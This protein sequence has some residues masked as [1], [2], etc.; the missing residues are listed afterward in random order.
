MLDM[1]NTICRNCIVLQYKTQNVDLITYLTIIFQ[2]YFIIYIL[3]SENG[4]WSKWNK[5]T[6]TFFQLDFSCRVPSPDSEFERTEKVY[7]NIILVYSETG[8]LY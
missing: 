3:Q 4:Q 1:K 5:L 6:F 2:R 7:S 8:F